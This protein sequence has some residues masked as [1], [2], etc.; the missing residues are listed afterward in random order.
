MAR[1]YETAVVLFLLAILVCGLAWVA[2]ALL[3]GDQFSRDTLFGTSQAT[4][5]TYVYNHRYWKC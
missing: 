3:D 1:V 4:M 5:F 2:S